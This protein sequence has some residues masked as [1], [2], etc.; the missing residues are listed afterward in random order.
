MCWCRCLELKPLQVVLISMASKVVAI[1]KKKS[2]GPRLGLYHHFLDFIM[3]KE[4]WWEMTLCTGRM[5]CGWAPCS[6][7]FV[8]TMAE[9]TAPAVLERRQGSLYSLFPDHHVEKY[10]DQV[11]ISN[12]LDWSMDHK[13]FYYI[14]S[15]SYSVD[16]FDY[17]LQTGKICM[18]LFIIFRGIFFTCL[19]LVSCCSLNP[20][21]KVLIFQ[22]TAQCYNSNIVMITQAWLCCQSS[23]GC[24]QETL[25]QSLGL[26][27]G[28]HGFSSQLS[29]ATI[30]IRWLGPQSFFLQ[31]S[32]E[33]GSL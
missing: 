21:E 28:S 33:R 6:L 10:F 31:P 13:I 2:I 23:H 29:M 22:R 9:E 24:Q 15:L 11:D 3:G 32:L 19:W 16:A 7:D 20:F 27:H 30:V 8:G 12:G 14:D 5:L 18:C 1:K 4:P 17:D 26:S 25:V